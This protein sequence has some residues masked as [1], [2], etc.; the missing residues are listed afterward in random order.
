MTLDLET[1]KRIVEVLKEKGATRACEACGNPLMEL[2]PDF[3][4]S[5]P[6]TPGT[7]P[8]VQIGKLYPTFGVAC[9]RCGNVRFHLMGPLGLL[10]L[11]SGGQP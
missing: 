4:T 1:Q 9:P 5:T 3:F 8:A 2:L 10:P 11:A 6:F 7:P